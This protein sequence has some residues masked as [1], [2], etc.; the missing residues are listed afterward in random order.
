[1][2]ESNKDFLDSS[3]ICFEQE[4]ADFIDQPSHPGARSKPPINYPIAMLMLY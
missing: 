1:V 4:N 2:R 3:F